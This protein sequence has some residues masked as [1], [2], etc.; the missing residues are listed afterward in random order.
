[1]NNSIFTNQR[2]ARGVR[3]RREE[4][5]FYLFVAPWIAGFVLFQ[6]GPMVIALGVSLTD[7]LLVSSPDWRGLDHY[8]TLLSDHRFHVA[9]RNTL[10][11]AGVSVPL[12]VGFAFCLASVLNRPWTGMGIFRTIFFMPALVSGVAVTLVWGWLF[13]PRLGAVNGVLG[14]VGL[15]QPG[16]LADPHWAMPTLILLSAWGVGGMMLIYLAALRNI[17]RDLYDA[18]VLDGAG[19]W[20]MLR[21]ITLPMISPVTF[22][23]VV[24][25]TI[26]ALQMFTPALVLTNGGPGD[27]TLT[28]PLYIYQNAFMWQ[29]YGYS[30]A[31][32]V[33]LVLITLM[34]TVLQL[35][36]ARR[37]VFYAGG[38]GR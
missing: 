26:G 25:A 17:P 36:I 6:A 21:H 18:A 11:Y 7:W 37:W 32:T 23:L 12:G 30:A 15:P 22:F 13:N 35:L 4:R 10:Y 2:K 27:A 34:L 5:L 19:R 20:S 14:A 38:A 8:R 29:N 24:V 3:S 28:L 33:F 31:L 16:W 9:L 1:M